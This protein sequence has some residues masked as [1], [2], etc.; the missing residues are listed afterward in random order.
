ML[1]NRN[2]NEERKSPAGENG[3]HQ[4]IIEEADGQEAGEAASPTPAINH[5]RP[6]GGGANQNIDIDL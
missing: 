6:A 4:E 3:R 5:D 1:I 2:N